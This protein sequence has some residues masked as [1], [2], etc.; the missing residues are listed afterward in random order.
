[1]GNQR[2][3]RKT[4]QIRNVFK[5]LD[6]TYNWKSNQTKNQSLEQLKNRNQKQQIIK[7]KKCK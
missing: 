2:K 1:V 3:W 5:K 4:K 6:E 7:R